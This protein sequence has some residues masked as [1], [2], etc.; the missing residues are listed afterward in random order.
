W[1][2]TSR[3]E[4]WNVSADRVYAIPRMASTTERVTVTRGRAQDTRTNRRSSH[5]V[6]EIVIIPVVC[7][8][9]G[10]LARRKRA[11]VHHGRPYGGECGYSSALMKRSRRASAVSSDHCSGGD[12]MRKAEGAISAPLRPRSIAIL[13]QRMASITTPA[14]LGESQTS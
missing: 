9:T 1:G 11:P 2:S 4:V 8:D 10:S 7:A 6:L 3:P 12:F 5:P 14:E 13:Q